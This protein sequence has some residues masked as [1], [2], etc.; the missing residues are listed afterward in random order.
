MWRE[1][2]ETLKPLENYT[3]TGNQL[4]RMVSDCRKVA[5]TLASLRAS[6]WLIIYILLS[7]LILI[8]STYLRLR[9]GC[10]VLCER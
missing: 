9:G 8:E 7:P 3:M 6:P 2:A 5:Y 10:C 4:I 1:C